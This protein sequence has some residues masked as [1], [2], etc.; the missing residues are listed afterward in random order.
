[1]TRKAVA[2]LARDP[3]G[4]VLLVEGGRIDQAHHAA[5]AARALEDTVAFDDAIAEAMRA[6]NPA[7]TLIIVTADHSHTLAIGG[8]P[9]RANPILGLVTGVDGKLSLAADGKPYTT[10]SY[11]NGPGAPNGARPDLTQTD[12]TQRDFVQPALVPLGG[13]THGGD[14]VAIFASGPFAHLFSGVVDENYIYHVMAHASRIPERAGA[15]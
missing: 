9:R 5:N 6:T 15:R 3:E 10:L 4:F 7:D 12:T 11:A 8:Y 13:E 14:D 1:M 2:L